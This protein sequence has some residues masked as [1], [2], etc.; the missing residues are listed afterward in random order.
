MS[1]VPETRY[2]QTVD[3]VRIAYQVWG[4]GPRDLVMI[5]DASAP[6]DCLWEEPRIAQM[7]ERLGSFSRNI[8]FDARGWGSSN[9]LTLA[10]Q[11]GL[12]AWLDDISAVMEAAG[13]ERAVIGGMNEG[14]SP[15]MLF[16]AT[17]P[18]RV[19]AVV[20]VNTFA[21]FVQAPDYDCGLPPELLDR[22]LD[23][24][25]ASWGTLDNLAE[26]MAP[27]MVGDRQWSRWM[28]RAQRLGTSPT[29]VEAF[30]RSVSE[31]NVHH[32]LPSIQAPTLVVHRRGDRHVRAEHGRYLAQHIPGAA[33]KELEG[34]DHSFFAGDT[35]GLVDEMEE[36]L[37]GV[38]PPRDTERVLATILFTDIVSSTQRATETGDRAWRTLLDAHDATVRSQL[39]RHRGRE[40][41]TMGDGFLAVFDGPARAIHC[42][43]AVRELLGGLGLDVRSGLHTGRSRLGGTTSLAS[44]SSLD[45]AY[46]AWPTQVRSW[47]RPLSRTSSPGPASSSK[48]GETTNSRGSLEPGDCLPSGPEDAE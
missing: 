16:A 30:M 26:G 14:G 21:R 48:N 8:W 9:V 4:E 37:T 19:S 47:S 25:V 27:S 23:A 20:L 41:K 7:L 42:A 36:F 12:D 31:T 24:M 34:E 22:Y 18:Q 5:R 28:L 11:P 35:D 10:G 32:V 45:N 3:G 43:C 15:T 17:Y 40:V 2:A 6:I 1:E 39:L 46:P 13:S 29:S 44:P 38:R 33:Y